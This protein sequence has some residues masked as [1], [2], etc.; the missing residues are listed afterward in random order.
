MSPIQQHI[1]TGNWKKVFSISR[2]YFF[3]LTKEEKRDIEIASDF[4]NG[5]ESFYTA[6]GIDCNLCFNNA[7]IAIIKKFKDL[8]NRTA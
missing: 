5:K 3:G 6:L 2:K 7:K 4:L 8:D 1:K